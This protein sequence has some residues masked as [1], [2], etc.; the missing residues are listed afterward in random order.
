VD[1]GVQSDCAEKNEVEKVIE[2]CNEIGGKSH[3]AS[4]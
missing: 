2:R 4:H 1:T 3:G